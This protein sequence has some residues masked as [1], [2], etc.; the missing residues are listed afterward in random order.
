MAE[1]ID[2]A[3]NPKR[4]KGPFRRVTEIIRTLTAGASL[5]EASLTL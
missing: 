1:S 5:L 2:H 3:P 4:G